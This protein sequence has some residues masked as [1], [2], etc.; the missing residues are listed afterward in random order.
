[1]QASFDRVGKKLDLLVAQAGARG[2]TFDSSAQGDRL[3]LEQIRVL[4]EASAELSV[5][6]FTEGI[7]PLTAYLQMC[8]LVGRLAAFDPSRRVPPLPRYDHDDLGGCFWR[9][10]QYLDALLDVFVE[11]AYKERPLIGAGLRMEVALDP[12]WLNPIW[13]IYLG[14]Q[15]SLSDEE[16]I[17]MLTRPGHLDMKVGSAD[18]VDLLYRQGHAGLSFVH[19]TQVPQALPVRP[20]LHFFR[21]KRDSGSAEWANVERSLTLAIRMNETRIL[22]NIHGQKTLTIQT[23]PGQTASLQ[24]TLYVVAASS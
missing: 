10:K 16:C 5:L 22:G 4:N 14:V 17:R 15:T 8:R 24:F 20:G 3:L 9:L 12:T 7:H 21:I 2:V 11:P 13:D 23:A 18:R 6:A 1:L 19:A